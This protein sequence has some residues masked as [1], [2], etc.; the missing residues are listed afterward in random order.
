[1]PPH[2]K[3][4]FYPP[5]RR[6]VTLILFSLTVFV[7]SYNLEAP[8]NYG[9]Y[10]SAIGLGA[11]DPGYDRD[12]R[13]PKEW[14]DDLET[15]I[16]GEWEWEEG[17]GSS[18][19]DGK[20]DRGIG[21]TKGVS[22]RQ[23]LVRWEEKVPVARAVAHVPGFTILD[24]V[25]MVNGTFYLVTDDPSSLPALEYVASS[26]VNSAHPP[27]EN[28]W[29][30]VST[31]DAVDKLGTF[32]GRVFGTSWFALD[33]AESQDPYT[34]FSLFRTH[35]TLA[36]PT[37]SASFSSDS[38]AQGRNK[39]LANVPAPL[40]LI[41]P[42]V[43]T[44][45]S[46][47]I[48]LAPGV[49]P[50]VHP[51]PR[52]K[53]FMGIHPLLQKAALPALG[54]WYTE[55]WQDLIAMNAPWI[56]DRVIIA[57]RGASERGRDLWTRGWSPA[58]EDFTKRA[59]GD[60]GKPSWAAPFV[61]LRM[62]AG[63]WTPVRNAL[64]SYLR[65]PE[66]QEATLN[67]DDHAALVAGLQ[68]LQ[69]DGVVSE[70][71]VV[72]GNGSVGVHGWEWADRMSAIARSSIV[73][74]PWGHH[75]ADSTFMSPPAWQGRDVAAASS[76]AGAEAE[77]SAA[78]LLM[79]FFPP[80]TFMRDQEFAVR[81]LGMRYIAWWNNRKFTANTLPPVFRAVDPNQRVPISVDAVMQAIRDEIARRTVP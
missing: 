36:A 42:N 72:K 47:H 50:K 25:I 77:Q 75:L 5:T 8:C 74:G 32:G 55:D 66:L 23:Q 64:L 48:P 3:G 6:E 80:D 56:F 2:Y 46:P 63:W 27:R 12:G 53:S 28:E 35:S 37:L 19:A 41:F 40:R 21:V 33:H 68:S 62:K 29:A 9:S 1:M 16:S 70:V 43:P 57:D 51:E 76:V 26:S 54:I 60:D 14:R 81:S 78:P 69:R 11:Q 13:R 7:L 49:D 59:E 22:P 65:L 24:N 45:S 71:H 73:L 39:S 10:L 44:F 67:E 79:E 17:K 38:S 34:L 61:G 30:I 4:W 15:M 20:V 58:S 31:S 18:R 52:V